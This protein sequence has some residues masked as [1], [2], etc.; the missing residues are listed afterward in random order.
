MP[1]WRSTRPRPAPS[2]TPPTLFPDGTLLSQEWRWTEGSTWL[3]RSDTLFGPSGTG[4][5]TITDYRNGY[6]WGPGTGP[7]GTAAASYT[8]L[9]SITPEGNVLFNVII[10]GTLTS[11]AGQITGTG[12]DAKMV[13]RSYDGTTFGPQA[14]AT[15]QFVPEPSV[16]VMGLA[17]VGSFFTPHRRPPSR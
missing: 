4:S 1:R 14:L 8:Q 5:F 3:L 12:W 17:V 13:L 7:D 16:W 9:G 11:L 2:P 15:V 10:G 6:F